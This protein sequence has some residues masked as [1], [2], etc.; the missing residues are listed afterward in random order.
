MKNTS[1]PDNSHLIYD[2][3]L[4]TKIIDYLFNT[5]DLKNYRYNMLEN[6]KQLQHLKEHPHFVSP[7]F[8]GYSYYLLFVNI[9]NIQY[10]VM[11]DKKKLSY[12]KDKLDVKTTTIYKIKINTFK[13]IY[14]GTIFDCKLIKNNNMYFMLIND[15]YTLMGNSMISMKLDDKLKYINNIISNHMDNNSNQ[16]FIFKVNKL[17]NYQDLKE[18]IEDIIPNCNLETNGIVFYP[19]YSGITK[20]FINKSNENKNNTSSNIVISNNNDINNLSYD[21]IKNYVTILHNRKYSYETEGTVKKLYLE[22]T[23]M[24]DVYNVYTINMKDKYGIAHIPNMKTSHYCND[25][26]KNTNIQK[27]NCIY[28]EHFKKWIPLETI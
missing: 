23:D 8:R 25:I 6:I 11:V 22:K 2:L 4:K 20:I 26:F 17:Y 12:H 28:N 7:N 9:N 15:C 13:N 14:R 19:L 5:I 21:I 18:L 10:C 16:Y 1:F 27:F 24:V 3:D